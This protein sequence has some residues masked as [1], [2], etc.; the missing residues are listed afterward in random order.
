MV[1]IE[2][3][4]LLRVTGLPELP[5]VA[6]TVPVWP[7]LMLVGALKISVCPALLIIMLAVRLAGL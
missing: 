4:V 2:V 6:E 5:P 1:Q 7:T 3:V